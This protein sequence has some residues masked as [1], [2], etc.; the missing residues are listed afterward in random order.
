[1]ICNNWPLDYW[2]PNR[3][4]EPDITLFFY[5]QLSPRYQLGAPPETLNDDAQGQHD[6]T[7][8][9]LQWANSFRGNKLINNFTAPMSPFACSRDRNS[10]PWYFTSYTKSNFVV[11]SYSFTQPEGT[12][13]EGA[14]NFITVVNPSSS[15]RRLK[16]TFQLAVTA[17]TNIQGLVFHNPLTNVIIDVYVANEEGLT[18]GAKFQTLTNIL[19]VWAQGEKVLGYNLQADKA[20]DLDPAT[21]AFN[22]NI[23]PYKI[24]AGTKVTVTAS[25]ARDGA[26]GTYMAEM[27]TSRFSL[28]VSLLSVPAIVITNIVNNGGTTATI[29]W[30]GGDAP[31]ILEKSTNISS[32]VWVPILTNATTTA[33][34]PI[35]TSKAF[36]R[37]Q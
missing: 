30:V 23:A 27:H 2:F 15:T 13:E 28:P 3:A 14:T 21:G 37:V 5:H 1:V 10:E 32:G 9:I 31:Y 34:V 4:T 17:V 11:Q 26:V 36:F 22:F 7:E 24:P 25:Y 35:N 19:P 18:N 6:E 16:G 12:A 8:I 33:T 29:T 20:G